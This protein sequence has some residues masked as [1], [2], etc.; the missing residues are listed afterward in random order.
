VPPRLRRP[1]LKAHALV[2]A[3]LALAGCV[4]APPGPT[5][6]PTPGTVAHPREVNII[7]REYTFDPSTVDLVPGETVL[8]HV[9]NAGLEIHE[10]VIGDTGIQDA[11]EVAEAAVAGAPPGPTP[12]VSVPP[13]RAGLRV[14][15]ASGQ[16]VDAIWTVPLATTPALIVGCHI[17][18]HWGKG[19]QVPVRFIAP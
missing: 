12:V 19:M 9:I 1:S 8:L 5:P 18:G 11:W 15:V 3:T 16:R 6:I 17:P 4:P 2:L 10:A 14:V 13:D 7:A